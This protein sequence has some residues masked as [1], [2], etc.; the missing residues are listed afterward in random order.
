M[1]NKSYGERRRRQFRRVYPLYLRAIICSELLVK[2]SADN[3][4]KTTYAACSVRPTLQD[5]F[6]MEIAFLHMQTIMEC[7]V[8]SGAR[9]Y[10]S[11]LNG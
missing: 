10:I 5:S 11:L 6:C 9:L 7:I 2:P 1:I 3:A 4:S 8:E